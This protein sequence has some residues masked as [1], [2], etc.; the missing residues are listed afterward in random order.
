M[1]NIA[2]FA[3]GE[4]TNAQQFIDY[5]HTGETHVSLVVSNNSTA[6]VLERAKKS[7]IPVFILKD[8][9]IDLSERLK[10]IDF[11]V[12]AGYLKKIPTSI[13]AVF[14]ERIVN[15]HPALL[16]KYG[17]KGMFGQ[18]VHKAVLDNKDKESGISIHYVNE[19]YD[20]GKIIFQAKCEINELDNEFTLAD[21]VH[22]LEHFYYPR[23]VENLLT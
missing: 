22:K 12:L 6:H 10:Q 1:K 17:G 7:N 15:I 4:G 23:I 11:I 13:C 3:S 20:E 9:V 16:P 19:N 2:I 8:N 5:F 14:N 21:K 18:N